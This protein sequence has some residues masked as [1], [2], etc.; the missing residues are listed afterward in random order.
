MNQQ[1]FDAWKAAVE[2]EWG[3]DLTP[4]LRKRFENTAPFGLIMLG[5][6]L[7]VSIL[8]TMAPVT[9]TQLIESGKSAEA[10]ALL[11]KAQRQLAL[12]VEL[13]EMSTSI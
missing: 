9:L 1:K 12:M 5:L 6:V 2:K 11:E 10:R 13:D 3:D 7:K 4:G 8:K